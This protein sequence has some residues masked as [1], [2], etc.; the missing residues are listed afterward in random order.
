[1]AA[2]VIHS[3]LLRAGRQDEIE[4][5]GTLKLVSAL[6]IPIIDIQP[7]S[8]PRKIPWSCFRFPDLVTT[9]RVGDQRSRP[10]SAEIS[11][12]PG[13]CGR[14]SSELAEASEPLA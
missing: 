12:A 5:A 7:L 11:S 2:F 13:I 9:T 3:R 4:R 1:M 6:G 14:P 8:R 10:N